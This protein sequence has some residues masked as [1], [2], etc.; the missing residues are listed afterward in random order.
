VIGA[1]NDIKVVFDDDDG[2]AFIGQTVDDVDKFL[3]VCAVQ[4]GCRFVKDEE[5]L[6]RLF[7]GKVS[8]QFDALRLAAGKRCRRLTELDIAKADI[9]QRLNDR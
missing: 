6:A 3:Y 4:T 7:A 5:R 8:C 2:V 9:I 1:F